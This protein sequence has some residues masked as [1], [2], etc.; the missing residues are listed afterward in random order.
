RPTPRNR[1]AASNPGKS[2]PRTALR[3]PQQQ[4][5]GRT[6]T[7]DEHENRQ[8]LRRNSPDVIPQIVPSPF[9]TTDH[10]ARLQRVVF[11]GALIVAFA[12]DRADF[13]TAN[14]LNP[15]SLRRYRR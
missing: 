5:D 1:A 6:E 4:A 13:R 11:A 15:A 10:D 2:A 7:N 9:G 12:C 3:P 8:V 14:A